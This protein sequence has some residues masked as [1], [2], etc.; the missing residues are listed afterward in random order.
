L[1]SSVKEN[2]ELTKE[3]LSRLKEKIRNEEN[4]LLSFIKSENKCVEF[5]EN[6]VK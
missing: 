6:E 1:T 5:C 4:H 3:Q 2:L